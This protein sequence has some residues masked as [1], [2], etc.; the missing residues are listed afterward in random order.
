[1][2]CVK[3]YFVKNPPRLSHFFFRV[4]FIVRYKNYMDKTDKYSEEILRYL[5]KR[6]DNAI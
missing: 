6:I 5:K 1:M 2:R 3:V 4:G